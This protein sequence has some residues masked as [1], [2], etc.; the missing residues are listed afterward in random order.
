MSYDYY[1]GDQDPRLREPENMDEVESHG[2]VQCSEC[3]EFWMGDMIEEM[4]C[5]DCG[6]DCHNIVEDHFDE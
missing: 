6:G 5:P 3:C 4:I 1:S 2:H